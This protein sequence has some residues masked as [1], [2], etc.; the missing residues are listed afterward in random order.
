MAAFGHVF[1]KIMAKMLENDIANKLHFEYNS[2]KKQIQ[3]I[4]KLYGQEYM[5]LISKL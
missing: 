5:E 4:L 2:G 1:A 3:R